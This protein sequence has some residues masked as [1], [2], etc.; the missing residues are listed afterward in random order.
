MCSLSFPWLPF[1]RILMTSCELATEM[2][3]SSLYLLSRV[4]AARIKGMCENL[5][6]S[7]QRRVEGRETAF[8]VSSFSLRICNRNWKVESGPSLNVVRCSSGNFLLMNVTNSSQ[9]WCI[10]YDWRTSQMSLNCKIFIKT[11]LSSTGIEWWL[12]AYRSTRKPP[13][14][15]LVTKHG[16]STLFQTELLLKLQAVSY[17]LD[18][19]PQ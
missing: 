7:H 16:K 2:E 4:T 12:L 6:M 18:M 11:V 5:K 13:K 9:R 17:S 19:S 8:R 3:R 1:L 15:L 14:H 10:H